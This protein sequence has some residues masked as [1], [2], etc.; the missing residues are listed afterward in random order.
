MKRFIKIFEEFKEQSKR[1]SS[2]IKKAKLFKKEV[3]V[4]DNDILGKVSSLINQAPPSPGP[5]NKL[6]NGRSRRPS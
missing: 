1:S 4:E 3:K 6:N 2:S 5:T